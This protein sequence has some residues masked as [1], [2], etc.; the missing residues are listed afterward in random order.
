ME[1]LGIAVGSL[2]LGSVADRMALLRTWFVADNPDG[3]LVERPTPRFCPI[4]S[5]IRPLV[6]F[7]FLAR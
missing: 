5:Y 1:L 3:V 4:S 6:N 7:N 2:L